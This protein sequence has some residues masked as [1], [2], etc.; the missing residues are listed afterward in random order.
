MIRRHNHS[1]KRAAFTL[2]EIIVVVAIILILA[3]AG[4]FVFTSVLVD[5][6]VGRAKMDIKNIEKAIEVYKV[7]HKQYPDDLVVLTNPDPDTG[8]AALLKDEALKDPW[9]REYVYE[10]GNTHPKTKVPHIYSNGPPDNPRIID[11]WTAD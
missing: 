3:G 11:N 7:K 6:N 9:K 2:M 1:T 8:E 10:K 4:V 5:A